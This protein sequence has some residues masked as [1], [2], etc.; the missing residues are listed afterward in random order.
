MVQDLSNKTIL[1]TSGPTF[2]PLDAVRALTNRST[3]RLGS[4]IACTLMRHGARVE[5]LAGETSVT[6][7]M[8]FPG[9]DLSGIRESRFYTVDQLRDGIRERLTRQKID[10]VCMAAAVLDYIPVGALEGKKRSDEEEWVIRL[11]RGE[12]IIERIRE[13]AP[14][15]L[16]VGFKLE[17]Q[18]SLEDLR[19]RASDLMRR[20]GA[21]LVV[22][23]RVEEIEAE[24][25]VA[26]LMELQ[27]A[28]GVCS[29]SAPLLSRESI[30]EA[31]ADRLAK[32]L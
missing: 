25:H 26:Y 2:A 14:E 22:A 21:R 18:I 5:M 32:T 9:E 3:G 16:L 1:V 10:V 29:V 28:D 4:V 15:V 12:K 27:E 7:S 13:W 30:A 6:P 31:L 11:R 23:N 17:S 8:L 19:D 20:S 24:R